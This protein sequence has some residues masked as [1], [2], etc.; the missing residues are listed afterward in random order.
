MANS[1]KSAIGYTLVLFA[2]IW[3]FLV[4]LAYLRSRPQIKIWNQA[5]AE[6]AEFAHSLGLKE[7]DLKDSDLMV[8]ILTEDLNA[9]YL[10][11]KREK[12]KQE[13]KRELDEALQDWN[14]EF[15]IVKYAA[16]VATLHS[17]RQIKST[18]QFLPGTIAFIVIL[19]AG[20]YFIPIFV[21]LN[22]NLKE[23]EETKS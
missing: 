10:A 5:K 11:I 14:S 23:P 6:T 15:Q 9:R 19:I 2:L 1:T 4:L 18:L 16:C 17:F 8:K 22:G 13:L 20:L 12:R 21:P 3:F 7:T